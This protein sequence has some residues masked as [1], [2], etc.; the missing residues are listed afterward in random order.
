MNKFI[1]CFIVII[2]SILL[3]DNFF[4]QSSFQSDSF[5][6]LFYNTENF[7]DYFDDPFTNDNDF[8]PKGIKHWTKNK[9]EKKR[10]NLYKIF[11]SAGSSE[12]PCLIGLCEI[13]N[14][15]VLKDLLYNTPFAKYNYRYIHKN[16]PDERGID[17]ALL[18]NPLMINVIDY[19]YFQ[20]KSELNIKLKT[21]DI[22]YCKLKFSD[23]DTFHFFINHW[24]SRRGGQTKSE[25]NRIIAAKIL[26]N[27]IDSL[28]EI[29]VNPKIIIMGD[30]NDEPDDISLTEYLKV[31][32][33]N[34]NIKSNELYNLSKITENSNANGT[35]KYQSNWYVFD[36]IIVSGNL[37]NSTERPYIAPDSYKII[38]NDF[39]MT[40]DEKYTGYKIFS[41]YSGYKYQGGFSDHLPVSILIKF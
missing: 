34:A 21:R 41:T 28:F 1:N 31:K 35:I 2:I 11:V 26:R 25:I 29:N 17:V 20:V 38:N 36:Q 10:N 5:K 19:K 6:I 40:E 4:A 9:Y 39:L 24:P 7:F 33:I 30:F 13:E 16:S 23:I 3:S 37:L 18:Y 32:K 8:T 14:D 12:P 27:K 15:Y 22:L